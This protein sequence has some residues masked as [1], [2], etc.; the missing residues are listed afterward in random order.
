MDSRP[1][2][3][4]LLRHANK[5]CSRSKRNRD[6]FLS[7]KSSIAR[8]NPSHAWNDTRTLLIWIAYCIL[9]WR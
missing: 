4:S 6:Y 3:Q 1:I 9:S 7:R 2:Q 5:T 8:G